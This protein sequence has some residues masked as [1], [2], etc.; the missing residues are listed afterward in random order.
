MNEGKGLRILSEYN[1]LAESSTD[2]SLCLAHYLPL[3]PKTHELQIDVIKSYG[4]Q[5]KLN[6]SFHT[7]KGRRWKTTLD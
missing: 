5:Y 7:V 4:L 1:S 2:S 6:L 3:T